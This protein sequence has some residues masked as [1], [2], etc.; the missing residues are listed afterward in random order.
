MKSPTSDRPWRRRWLKMGLLALVAFP[1]GAFVAVSLAVGS[2]V[3]AASD[4]ALQ[5]HQG[6]RVTALMEFVETRTHSLRERNRAVWALGQ[7][8]DSRALPLLEKHFTGGPCDHARALCQREL[9]KALEKCRGATNLT[10]LVWR[11]G[12]LRPRAA[13]PSRDGPGKDGLGE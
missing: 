2:G 5:A 7:L 12:S 8:G 13:H 4:A 1:I 3:R 10:A 11:H 6:D 9:G